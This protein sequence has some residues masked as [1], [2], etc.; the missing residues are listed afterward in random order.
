MKHPYLCVVKVS[1]KASALEDEFAQSP[2]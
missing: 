1:E 2:V